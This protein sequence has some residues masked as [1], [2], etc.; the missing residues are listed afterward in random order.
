MQIHKPIL[1]STLALAAAFT[2]Q[3]DFSYTTT[4]KATGGSMAAMAGAAMNQSATTYIEG[5]KYA[6][7]SG[8]ISTV[9]DFGAQTITTIDNTAKTYTVKK[10]SD[11][12]ANGAAVTGASAD[13]KETGQKKTINGFNASEVLLT[14]NIDMTMGRGA[15][16]MKM[17][18]EVHMWVS[19]DVPGAGSLRDFYKK[20][21]NNFPWAALAS[22]QGGT[23]NA[24]VQKALSTMQRKMAEMDGAPVEQLIVVKSADMGTQMAQTPAAPE[25]TPQ[26]QAQMQA[27]MQKMAQMQAQGGAQSAAAQQA[28]AAMAAMGRGPAAGGGSNSLIEI[29]MDESKFST[30][31]VPDSVFAIPEGYKQ[32]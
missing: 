17:Q 2:A 3:A 14:M 5:D 26:Q 29:T 28:M 24:S 19:P 32:Q 22:A 21:A 20:N 31:S 23:G 1:I 15:P 25:M 18:L 6:S 11:L 8:A 4:S 7:V 10:F 27:A 30:D 12:A 13:V 16:V 9:I